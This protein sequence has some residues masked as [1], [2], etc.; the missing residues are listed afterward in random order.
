[1]SRLNSDFTASQNQ[2]SA[3]AFQ[4]SN[5][6][7]TACLNANSSLLLADQAEINGSTIAG[8]NAASSN[9]ASLG[10]AFVRS[11]GASPVTT[12][13]N[14]D[15]LAVYVVAAPLSSSFAR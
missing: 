13:A 10:F 3:G 5:I 8:G 6:I 1:M 11:L 4:D 14:S 12:A 7:T 2:S 9:D 15:T